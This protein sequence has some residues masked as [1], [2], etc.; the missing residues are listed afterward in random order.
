MKLNRTCARG[1]LTWAFALIELLVVIAIISL[2][3]EPKRRTMAGGYPNW[4]A[5][6]HQADRR[7]GCFR[8]HAHRSGPGEN[9]F[10]I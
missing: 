3:R 7:S 5:H 1:A 4:R 6:A 10:L 2:R 9:D 8:Q